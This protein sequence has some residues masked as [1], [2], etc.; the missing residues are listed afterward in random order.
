MLSLFNF[1]WTYTKD[2]NNLYF[3]VAVEG[4]FLVSS[5]ILHM[6]FVNASCSLTH[7][8]SKTAVIISKIVNSKFCDKF[9]ERIFKKFLLQNQYRSLKLETLFF[10][11][12]WK[13]LMTVS[14]AF[15][16]LNFL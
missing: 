15:I 5:Y 10:T 14:E 9:R 7:E 2:F 8:A 11:I 1:Y 4:S 12:D 3:V 6:V 16:Y 13:L